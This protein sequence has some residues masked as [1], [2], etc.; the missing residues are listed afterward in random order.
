MGSLE[1]DVAA[2]KSTFM[3]HNGTVQKEEF[4]EAMLSIGS[5]A[6]LEGVRAKFDDGSYTRKEN[7]DHYTL[8]LVCRLFQHVNPKLR[9][10]YEKSPGPLSYL[11][12]RL[13]AMFRQL[14]AVVPS[15]ASPIVTSLYPTDPTHTLGVVQTLDH[16]RISQTGYFGL[17]QFICHNSSMVRYLLQ[18]LV[19]FPTS[20]VM[21]LRRLKDGILQERNIVSMP[22]PRASEYQPSITYA[23]VWK[24]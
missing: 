9:E 13:A 19:V 11:V 15:V 18:P 1:R 20:F 8:F 2:G 5:D 22:H 14:A 17:S 10:Q 24:N 6:L 4:C 23:R 12:H 7:N 21:I 16:H 3:S